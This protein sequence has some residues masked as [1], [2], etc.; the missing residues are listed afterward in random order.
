MKYRH[1]THKSMNA[2]EQH[3]YPKGFF[4]LLLRVEDKM[5]GKDDDL[6]PEAILRRFLAIA[7]EKYDLHT[8]NEHEESDARSCGNKSGHTPSQ[9]LATQAAQ[10]SHP[11][12]GACKPSAETRIAV[13]F[14]DRENIRI[15]YNIFS[16]EIDNECGSPIRFHFHMES[17]F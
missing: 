12:E 7:K 11:N 4:P 13:P 14:P 2:S 16:S 5:A 6:T 15:D 9:G 8:I 10:A 17:D 3:W 1:A